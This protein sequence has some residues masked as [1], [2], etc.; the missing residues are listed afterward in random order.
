[1]IRNWVKI[2]FVYLVITA[3]LGLFLRYILTSPVEGVNFRYFLHAH[4]HVAFLGWIF[5]ALFI[6]LIYCYIP[7]RLKAYR[8]LFWLLQV[9]VLGML[10]TFPVQGYAAASITFSTLHI[11]LSW[12]FAV[13]FHG[14]TRHIKSISAI[15][16]TFIRW[17]LIFMVISAIGPFSL[18]AIMAQGMSGS[19]LYNLSI[20]FYLHFQYNGWFSFA[21]FGMLFWVLEKN[22]IAIPKRLSHNFLILMLIATIPGYALSALWAQPAMWVYIVGFIA[23]IAQ[24][25]ALAYLIKLRKLVWP[26]LKPLMNGPIKNLFAFAFVA[27]VVKVVLQFISAF[28]YMA[29]L[30]YRARNFTIGYLHIVFLGFVTVFLIAWFWHVKIINVN[31]SG[32]SGIMIFLASFI[33]SECIIFLQP[34]L[35]LTGLGNLPY[36]NEILL[37][38]SSLMPVGIILLSFQSKLYVRSNLF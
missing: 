19:V 25:A 14:D 35:I 5:N 3:L 16:L 8:V 26:S 37:I 29:D 31:R 34:F 6:A 38:V 15:S 7:E 17:G 36:G 18:G 32:Y 1:M 22:G 4:S 12:W 23:A 28:P 21:V 10:F 2:S 20:Y 13:K 33:A 9:S 30:A 24:V 11:F 27:F